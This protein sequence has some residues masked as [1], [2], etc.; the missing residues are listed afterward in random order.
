MF[1]TNNACFHL[2]E[3][4]EASPTHLRCMQIFIFRVCN[5]VQRFSIICPV[6][7][8][9]V[10]MYNRVI[11]FNNCR[12]KCKVKPVVIIFLYVTQTY[13]NRKP[14]Y[15][16]EALPLFRKTL[17]TNVLLISHRS[18]FELLYYIPYQVWL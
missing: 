7:L 11:T 15:V 13:I 16:V 2:Y 6:W 14:V 17:A 3:S 1:P 12:E 10:T 18:T 8:S 5:S 9:L 4:L